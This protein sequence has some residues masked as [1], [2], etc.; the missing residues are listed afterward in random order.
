MA[1]ITKCTNI[2]CKMKSVCYRFTAE[3]GMFQ[4]YSDF[5]PNSDN[6]CD[7]FW[8]EKANKP[9]KSEKLVK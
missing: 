6:S 2:E 4:S 7:Y 3:A 8:Y 9:T 5:K 1:D